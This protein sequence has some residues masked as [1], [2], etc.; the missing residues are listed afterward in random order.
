[1]TA[2]PSPSPA[3]SR[4]DGVETVLF[5][6]VLGVRPAVRAW[7]ER[8]RAAGHV[9]HVP[10]LYDGE[11]FDDYTAAFAHVERIGGIPALIERTHAVV[12]HL[13]NDLVYAGFSNGSVSAQLLAATRPGARGALL[14]HGCVPLEMLGAERW[15]DGV[16]VQVHVSAGDPYHDRAHERALRESVETAGGTFELFRYPGA[17]H[18]FADSG[19]PAEY[20]AASAELMLGRAI[21]FVNARA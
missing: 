15:P 3:P 11:V 7:A 8:L 2:A 19:L 6:S 18:L 20:D 14:I 4:R 16:P 12:A 9:V 21:E 17:A 13:A 5:H 1:M 10:D